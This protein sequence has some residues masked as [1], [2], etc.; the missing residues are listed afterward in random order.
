MKSLLSLLLLLLL[1]GCASID[2]TV[3]EI[4]HPDGRVERTTR[5]KSL[6][7]GNAKQVVESTKLSN[8][9]TQSI[10]TSG[11]NQESQSAI[12]DM[13]EMLRELNALKP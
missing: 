12:R 13:A 11:A 5:N 2:Q 4:H 8:G 3:T 10:G 9:K 7:S 1:S 6:V